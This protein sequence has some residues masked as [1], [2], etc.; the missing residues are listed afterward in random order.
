VPR[1]SKNIIYDYF[2]RVKLAFLGRV[3]R[4]IVSEGGYKEQKLRLEEM[5][6]M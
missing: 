6:G 4:M 1:K 3:I 5:K 2:K